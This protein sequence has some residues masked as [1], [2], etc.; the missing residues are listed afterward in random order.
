M[1]SGADESR[2]VHTP[3][4]L[5]SSSGETAYIARNRTGLQVEPTEGTPSHTL[6]SPRY[7]S[8]TNT[9]PGSIL[10]E[11]GTL[12]VNTI[13]LFRITAAEPSLAMTSNDSA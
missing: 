13:S 10:Q 9:A 11:A 7:T 3:S 4:L 6:R 5:D 2:P 12:R 1:L 8:T